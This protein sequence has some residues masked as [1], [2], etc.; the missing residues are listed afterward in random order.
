MELDEDTLDG[1]WSTN[2]NNNME[3]FIINDAIFSKLCILGDDV[4]PCFEGAKISAPEVSNTFTKVDDNFKKTLF[5]M[6]QDL[7]FALQEG[8]I[9]MELDNQVAIEEENNNE[10]KEVVVENE[11]VEEVSK[12]EEEKENEDVVVEDAQEEKKEEEVIVEEEKEEENH[13]ETAIEEENNEEVIKEENNEFSLADYESLQQKYSDLE[14][15]YNGLLKFKEEVEKKEKE[16]LINS[17]YMLSDEDKKEVREHIAEYSLSDIEA[18][19]SIICVRNKVNFD[20]EDSTKNNNEI[21]E[22]NPVTTFNIVNEE[23][24]VPAW[25]SAC[26]KTQNS[27]NN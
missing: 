3:F 10:E 15:K 25:I 27:K 8:G 24:S 12:P 2:V 7:K 1:H 16:E 13:E 20:S 22:E 11:I 23:E 21:E 26:I 9:K 19:L 6:M 18:K 5:T 17:F 14:E 4:E